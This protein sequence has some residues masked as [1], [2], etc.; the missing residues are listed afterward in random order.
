[1]HAGGHG[2]Q[3]GD[4]LDQAR[5]QAGVGGG[6]DEEEGA[7][8]GGGAWRIGADGGN[9][10]GW[11]GGSPRRDR[12]EWGGNGPAPSGNPDG[13]E[14]DHYAKNVHG[15]AYSPAPLKTSR[16]TWRRR[17]SQVLP[18]GGRGTAS[19]LAQPAASTAQATPLWRCRRATARSAPRPA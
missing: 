16:S 3:L 4:G 1:M 8:G 6:G 14:A 17:V 18:A 5:Q 19:V 7:D 15:R 10:L 13:N 11:H 2:A 12:R 9:S